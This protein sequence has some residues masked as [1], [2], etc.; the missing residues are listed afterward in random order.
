MN[1]LEMTKGVHIQKITCL[2]NNQ[3]TPQKDSDPYSPGD[4]ENDSVDGNF[5][6]E[7]KQNIESNIEIEF[8]TVKMK[9]SKKK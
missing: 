3:S 6:D 4:K 9:S 8:N 2:K 5:D 7:Q 1:N